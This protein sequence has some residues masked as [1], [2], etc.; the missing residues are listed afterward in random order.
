MEK[1]FLFGKE[2]LRRAGRIQLLSVLAFACAASFNGD[3]DFGGFGEDPGFSDVI[4]HAKF[5]GSFAVFGF[6]RAGN[7]NDRRVFEFFLSAQPFD[8]F[9]T[10]YARHF[11]ISDKDFG[12]W[13]AIAVVIRRVTFEICEGHFAIFNMKNRRSRK[14]LRKKP[15]DEKEILRTVLSNQ[16]WMQ[17]IHA[18]MLTPQS[19]IVN[20][21]KKLMKRCFTFYG[22]SDSVQQGIDRVGFGQTHNIFEVNGGFLSIFSAGRNDDGNRRIDFLYFLNGG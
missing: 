16:Y 12:Q 3:N 6:I 5:A 4:H 15:V 19:L 8:E 14:F 20:I 10:C 9:K 21:V 1:S 2:G 11:Q 18:M 13:K 17:S 22:S 7:D